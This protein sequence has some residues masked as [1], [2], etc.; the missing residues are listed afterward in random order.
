QIPIPYKDTTYWCQMFKMPKLD[1]KHHVIKIEPLIQKGNENLVHHIVLYECAKD[2]NDTVL[3]YGHECY[4]PNMPD[5]FHTCEMVVFAWAVGGEVG[6]FTLSMFSPVGYVDVMILVL[7]HSFSSAGL[8]DNSGIRLY[9]TPHVR[10]YDAGVLETGIWVSLYHMIPPGMSAFRSEGHCTMECLEEALSSE[11]PEGIRVFAVLLHAHLAGQAIWARHYRNG[12]EQKL[13]AYDT[14]YDFN[15]QEYKY[16]EEERTIFPGD[17][18]I[19]QCQ[20]NTTGRKT[21]T[22]G[23]LSTKDEMCLSF[24]LYYPKINL[25]RCESIP[26]IKQQLEFIGVKEIYMPVT[27]WPFIIKSPKKYN[28]LSFT[29]AMNTYVWSRRKGN[30][31]NQRVRQIPMNVRCSKHESYEWS[32]VNYLRFYSF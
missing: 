22:W 20:Y 5:A 2:C 4:H 27:S 13:L 21:M 25:A 29:E 7:C 11:S 12:K 23:G 18:L 30:S 24:L 1:K 26:E 15:F 28:N 10:K 14:E 8:T 6:T 3:D 16:L 32:V 31:F 17:S 19:T 9:Y